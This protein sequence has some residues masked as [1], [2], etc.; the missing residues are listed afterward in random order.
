MNK[1][2]LLERIRSGRELFK[3]LIAELS[4]EQ[5]TQPGI[6]GDWSVKDILAHIVVHEQ[7]MLDWMAQRMHG[8]T[9]I[10]FQPYAMPDPELAELNERIYQENRGR[11]WANVV[12]DWDQTYELTQTFVTAADEADLM[13]TR[14]FHLQGGE[15]L[16]H[17]VAANTFEHYEEHSRDILAW[18]AG[19]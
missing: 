9:P 6:N 11:E 10:S 18:L 7:R 13:T 3:A 15:P 14:R 5:L 17:A 19:Q 8:E 12:Q 2:R 4:D 16:W 1:V